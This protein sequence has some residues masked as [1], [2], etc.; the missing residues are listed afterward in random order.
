MKTS[1]LSH[2]VDETV[3]QLKSVAH[4]AMDKVVHATGQAGEAL[5]EKGEQLHNLEQNWVK[6]C[7]GYVHDNP[8]VTLGIAVGVG[9]IL[10]RLLSSR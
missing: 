3:N 1:H 9:F 6:N 8:I 7:R 5:S 10:S 2:P 4:E